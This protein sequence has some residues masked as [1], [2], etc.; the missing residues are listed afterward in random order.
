MA[1][2]L[3]F[4]KSAFEVAL[5]FL[6]PVFVVLGFSLIS[7]AVYVHFT[8][9]LSWYSGEP[10][11]SLSIFS[12]FHLSVDIWLCIGIAWNYFKSAVTPALKF[13]VEISPEE[14]AA[15]QSSDGTQSSR[16]NT[17]YC[18]YCALFRLFPLQV[19]PFPLELTLCLSFR[20][21]GKA[22]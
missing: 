9:V 21:K 6:G 15:I 11:L 7:F 13:D 3:L 4:I 10:V 16:K 22:R 14:L 18:K 19:D 20:S 8:F 12:L 2:C 5:R 1:S 17:R